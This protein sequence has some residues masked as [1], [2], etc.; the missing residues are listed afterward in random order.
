VNYKSFN[1]LFIRL[2][3]TLRRVHFC[4]ASR[5]LL[6]PFYF[7][8]V[9]FGL[10]VSCNT[11][12]PPVKEQPPTAIKD[13]ITIQ[14]TQT[15]HRSITLNVK[16]TFNKPAKSIELY[17]RRNNLDSLVESYA[18]FTLEKEIIDDDSGKGLI[19]DTEYKYFAV[20][21]DSS[22]NL[23]D[24]SEI[25]TARTLPATSHD[26][27]WQ[28]YTI[29]DDGYSNALYDV[30][31]TDENNVYAVGGIRIKDTTYGV[32]HWD[33][34][35]W[36]PVLKR[37]G[38]NAIFGFLENDI[39]AIGGAV[40]HYDGIK[41]VRIDGKLVGNQDIP[42]DQVLFD[43]G[44]YTSIW[45]TSSDNL[46]L[47]NLWGKIVHWDGERGKIIYQVDGIYI[48]DISGSHNGD[49]YVVGSRNTS[50][51][52]NLVLRYENNNWQN[53]GNNDLLSAFPNTIKVFNKN[54]ILLGGK[55]LY[56]KQTGNW[57]KV[58]LGNSG[59][60]KKI[61]GYRSNNIFSVGALKEVYHFN[62]LDW[63][64]I[65]ELKEPHG[66]Y[67]SVIVMKNTVFIVGVNQNFSAQII[68]GRR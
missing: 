48:T 59:T 58:F 35:K 27:T 25:I 55:Y 54:L 10:L 32:I 53:I 16:S 62:G 61:R 57:T 68:I 26:Y 50:S 46:Y 38:F 37:G 21:V 31:G 47:G 13:T 52:S 64:L 24:T 56:L 45:G 51:G 30:W 33:G 63:K 41:W 34:I 23:I 49:F 8:A 65:S 11:T 29:G 1:I 17:R 20:R 67:S 42:L 12:E 18:A 6:L 39:W 40:F 43:N 9:S 5:G 7:C 3:S 4:T 66:E 60:I 28:E 44:P 2:F 15:T 14:V 22:N 36:K 19:I